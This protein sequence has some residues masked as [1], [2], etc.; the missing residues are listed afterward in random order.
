MQSA[1]EEL[2]TSKEELQSI[3][4][5]L[6][7]INAELQNKNE[8]LAGVNNDIYNL[9]ASTEIGTIFLDLDLHMRRFTP[10]VNRIYNFLPADIGRPID[11]FVSNL[12]YDRLVEDIQQVLHTL[13]PKAIEV[14]AKD[15][16]WYLINIRPYRTLENVIDGAVITFVDISE[17]KQGDELRR[18][19]TI[20]RDSN[21]AITVQDFNGKILA[22]N[23]GAAQMYGWTEAKP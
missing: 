13:V 1:N 22:W 21:D 9:L 2:E 8:E 20:L 11:H 18:M 14:Q 3:N 5:E 16:A 10:A 4:E 17:Q 23:R 15:G 7:T 12:D 19:G 6:T